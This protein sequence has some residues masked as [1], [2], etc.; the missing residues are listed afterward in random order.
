MDS[1][2]QMRIFNSWRGQNIG[3]ALLVLSLN[4]ETTKGCVNDRGECC[5]NFYHDNGKCI[6]CPAG[7]YGDNCSIT[8]SP[9][10]YGKDCRHRCTCSP[11]E[12]CNPYKGCVRIDT[13]CPTGSYGDN[14][15]TTCPYPSWGEN[16]GFWC[17]CSV[18]EVCSP[19]IG[20]VKT[21]TASTFSTKTKAGNYMTSTQNSIKPEI[22]AAINNTSCMSN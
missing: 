5:T 10:F 2:F 1:I 18:D 15:S 13:A 14:C 7:S 22:D 20:C 19:H 9:P 4:A 6:P 21:S 3:L 16:C 11:D 12:E 17:K 8:C